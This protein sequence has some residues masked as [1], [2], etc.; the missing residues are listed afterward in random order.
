MNPKSRV[1]P[2]SIF[3]SGLV[4]GLLLAG[5]GGSKTTSVNTTPTPTPQ[6]TSSC[7][8][9]PVTI[10][11]TATALNSPQLVVLS[12]SAYPQAVCNDGTAGAYVLIPGA[13]AAANRWIISLQ[14][15]GECFD[16]PTCATRA[17][18]MPTLVSTSSFQANPSS[19]F[20]QGGL[21]GNTPGNN[22]DFY[23]AS[24]VQ[25]LYCSSDDWSG[26]KASATA[27]NP[28]DPTTWNFEG[29][30]ILDSVLADLKASHNFSSAT[31]VMFTGQSA[32]GVGVFANTNP[33]AKLV[34]PAARYVSYS[35]AAF[36]DGGYDY[37]ATGSA[38]NY[39]NPTAT[40]NQIAKR[41][42]ALPLWNGTGDPICSAATAPDPTS[43]TFCYSGQTLLAPTTGTI[44]LPML[45]SV[46]QR[47]T[48]QLG[49]AG[50]SNADINSGSPST[51][52]YINYFAAT[53]HTS[54]SSTN[55]NVSLFSPDFYVH[56]EATD[57]AYYNNPITF[58]AGT[59]TLQQQIG[60]WYKAP[61]SVQRN[62]AN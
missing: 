19:A 33:V 40:P 60:A 61:C 58:P 15:G 57:P 38:P 49:T 55:A 2:P 24:I 42:S 52:G 47:D 28:N 20:G 27:Y 37:L 21:L 7:S 26:A 45:V 3:A 18:T 17:A 32:G 23:D 12:K 1:V 11:H 22:P 53:M 62:I 29:R 44:T 35:D 48:N 13:G 46:S 41:I 54:V 43:Q 51:T 6:P 56:V 36:P 25:V 59:I 31:E 39:D 10:T 5:C 4:A 34:P 14:G 9:A 50:I 8:T 16:Q 30:A